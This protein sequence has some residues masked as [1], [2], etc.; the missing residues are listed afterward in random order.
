MEEQI[1]IT[2]VD[3]I[4]FELQDYSVQD[5][6]IIAQFE[7][8]TV[9]SQSTDYIEYFI[10]DENQNLIFPSTTQELLTYTVKNGDVLL[11]PDQ[12]L[13]RL[14]FDE[15]VYFISYNFYRKRLA[16]SIS[17]LYYIS[18]I[19]SDRTEIRLDS[20]TISNEDIVSSTNEFIQYRNLSTYFV[21]FYLNFGSN[22]L[23]IANNIRL[24][25]SNIGDPTILIKLYEPLPLEFDL[26]SQVWTVEQLS[27]PQAYQVQFPTIPFTIQDFRYISGPNFNLNLQE[28]V[29]STSQEFSLDTLLLSNVTSSYN[30]LQSLLNEKGLKINVNYEDFNEFIHFSSAKTRLEN[31]YYKVSLIEGYNNLAQALIAATS[32]TAAVTSSIQSIIKNF[33]NYEYFLYYNSG[34]QYSWPKSNTEPPYT[35]YSTGS[36][37]V[38]NWIGSADVISPY[39]GGL[40]LSASNYDQ[41]NQDW[42]YW[43]T[44]EYIRDDSD[45]DQYLLFVDMIGQHFDNIWVYTKDITNKFSADNRLDY[46][47]SKDLVADAIRD[48]GVKLYANNF[49]VDDLYTAFLGIT[50]SGSLFPYPNQTSTLPTPSGNE[51]IDTLISASSDVIPLD[52]ANKR[53]YKRIYHNLPYLFKTKGTIAG[54]RALVTSYGIPDTIL[55]IN[56]FGGNIIG[57]L[58]DRNLKQREFNYAFDTSGKYH[59]SSSFVPNTNFDSGRP[60]TIQ[61]RFKT[62][63]LPT[64]VSQSL[65]SIDNGNSSLVL[66]YTGSKL[67]SGSY[68]GSIPD[69]YNE[70]GTLKFIPNSST[71]SI[72]ASV[73]LPFFDEGWWSVMTTQNGTTATLYAANSINNTLGFVSSSSA[74][75]YSATNYNNGTV[76]RFPNSSS[77]THSSKIY[78]PFSGSLQEIRYYVP[79]ISAS[80]FYDYVLNPYSSEGNGIN[81]SPNE[82]MFRADLGTLSDTGSRE[83]IHPKVSGS[84]V[85]ITSSFA[86]NSNFYL[87]SSYFVA[88]KEIINENQLISGIKDR[89][90][91]KIQVRPNILAANTS[92]SNADINVL[93]PLRSIQQ[94]SDVSGSFTE[95][96]NYLEVAFSPQDQIND[97]IIAQLGNFNLGDYIGDPRQISSSAVNYPDLDRLRDA[98]FEK[99]THSYDVVDFI[100]LIKFFDNSLFRMIKDFTPARTSLSS[101]VVVKQHILERNR[102]RPAQV[103]S[104]N[105]TLE[106][107]VKPFSR[108]YDTGS[109]DTGQY[110]YISG[111]SIYRFSGGTGGSFEQFNGTEF[112]PTTVDNIYNVTQS[113][114]EYFPS[115]LGVVTY[116]R[117]DQREFYNGEFSGSAP[118]VKLQ[119]GLGNGDDPCATT[120]KINPNNFYVYDLAFYSGSDDNFIIT[121]ESIYLCDFNGLTIICDGT[122]TTTTTSTSTTSTT[123]TS[124]TTTTAAPVHTFTSTPYGAV[125]NVF[126]AGTTTSSIFLTGSPFTM[127]TIFPPSTT[128]TLN[129]INGSTTTGNTIS[130]TLS[131]T[132]NATAVSNLQIKDNLGT[133]YTGV[134]SGGS[135]FG[136]NI[137]I[138]FTLGVPTNKT[139]GFQGGIVNLQFP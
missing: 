10:F 65:W 68:S 25:N 42:L 50:P 2:P 81:S 22:N 72:S 118:Y 57:S 19:S 117:D 14:G 61:F 71:P 138:T 128:S 113:W 3:P 48:F 37:Q 85:Y 105:E 121:S 27:T 31:F 100:R 54:L 104:S 40:A 41:D 80:V 26:K 36:S 49:S 86:S 139:F 5:T 32:S 90:T 39:Y 59:F 13:S 136:T 67:V 96:V 69:P 134:V 34:S 76:I 51:Y 64:R 29:G 135:G 97:D 47:I 83:S 33:D 78:L 63:G 133:T 56:E 62:D 93:S 110:E 101:G 137:A 102:V 30:Q 116:D 109:G 24:D 126:I 130:F 88:N 70:Y 119:R 91:D 124:T 46:G 4:T 58:D 17:S 77:I 103:T 98:Y 15:G 53:L 60:N 23:V 112:Y 1:L 73:Y 132:S 89:V 111:S 123:T 28:Q 99:Y 75:G 18:D 55:K 122:T 43:A 12:D 66:E 84:T 44:P 107:L 131:N 20:T 120:L 74:T 87:S 45:N 82:L 79:T 127:S 129:F 35:L 114:D 108:G 11:S 16:S 115:Q 95:N 21:D 92:G 7:V 125:G 8:D 38:L 106:G 9:F 52:D 94:N 6:N